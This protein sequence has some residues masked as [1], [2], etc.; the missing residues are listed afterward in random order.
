MKKIISLWIWIAILFGYSQACAKS[1]I[2]S[3]EALLIYRISD[4]VYVH[5]SYLHTEEWGTVPCNGMIIT[6]ANE[7]VVLDTPTDDGSSLEL[8]NWIV[9]NRCMV[10]TDFLN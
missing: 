2:Y 9:P 5:V 3:S 1:E 7:A 10:S 6:H 8:I 4:H